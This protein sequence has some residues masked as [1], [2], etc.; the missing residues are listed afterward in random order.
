MAETKITNKT[1]PTTTLP[2]PKQAGCLD[3][4]ISCELEVYRAKGLL[5]QQDIQNL[6]CCITNGELTGYTL[7][8][9]EGQSKPHIR[10]TLTV[11]R[12]ASQ[13]TN[14]NESSNRELTPKQ[15]EEE[16][17]IA[18]ECYNLHNPDPGSNR[19]LPVNADARTRE[20]DMLF[21]NS[22]HVIRNDFKNFLVDER[23]MESAA[24]E[25]LA[26]KML[27]FWNKSAGAPTDPYLTH[28]FDYEELYRIYSS[29]V[30]D[31]G[32]NDKTKQ[33]IDQILDQV[34]EKDE[35]SF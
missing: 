29:T 8:Y 18:E 32:Y 35:E 17:S 19:P 12:D 15:R 4:A 16:K 21:V 3:E 10:E 23:G 28:N 30:R 33:A 14:S 25:T 7:G 2:T 31:G 20:C 1:S 6:E 27:D 26:Q 5:E 24:A 11:R 22:Q 9:K 34:P 13:E